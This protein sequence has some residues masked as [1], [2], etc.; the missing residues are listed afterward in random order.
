MLCRWQLLQPTNSIEGWWIHAIDHALVTLSSSREAHTE[1]MDFDL[2]FARW[3]ETAADVG[4]SALHFQHANVPIVHAIVLCESPPVIAGENGY[5]RCQPGYILPFGTHHVHQ[6]HHCVAS[7]HVGV[8]EAT[9]PNWLQH[10][11]QN[12]TRN[13]LTEISIKSSTGR[14]HELNP[15]PYD[16]IHRDPQLQLENSV[17]W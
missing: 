8:S 9:L 6:V 11:V 1:N 17:L 3:A 4:M 14:S 10:W 2:E 12:I 13:Q 16:L 5:R 7:W 15:K